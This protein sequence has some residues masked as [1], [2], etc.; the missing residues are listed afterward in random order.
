MWKNGQNETE[1]STWM[2]LLTGKTVH[3][4]WSELPPEKRFRLYIICKSLQSRAFWAGKWFAMPFY[5]AF[6][7]TFTLGTPF[8]RVLREMSTDLHL[9]FS[10]I[11]QHSGIQWVKFHTTVVSVCI[12]STFLRGQYSLG[13]FSFALLFYR[14]FCQHKS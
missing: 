10:Q 14:V 11:K 4:W 6:L 12:S 1:H 13:L 7:N 8:G 2:L 5:N 3:R 9:Q